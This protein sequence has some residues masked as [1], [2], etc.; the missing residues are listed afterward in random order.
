MLSA[1]ELGFVLVRDGVFA[2]VV[3][4]AVAVVAREGVA[5]LARKLFLILRQLHGVDYLIHLYLRKEV[6]SFLNQL[7]PKSFPTD[8]KKQ[9]VKMPQKGECKVH[10]LSPQP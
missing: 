7:D 2:L 1:L 6:R 4:V 5:G 8:G 9:V 3:L 10:E